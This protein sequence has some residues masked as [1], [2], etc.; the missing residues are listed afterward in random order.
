MGTPTE[1]EYFDDAFLSR[2][3]SGVRE[4]FDSC[5][6]N[7]FGVL[8]EP[9]DYNEVACVCSKLKLG[10]TGLCIDYE[11]ISFAGPPV[12]RLLFEMYQNFYA[13]GSVCESS[14]TG[15]ILP[16]FK[17]KR[18]KANNK[19]NYRGITL[20]PTLCKIYEMV[21]LNRLENYAKQNK[22]F[23][24]LQFGFQEGVGC[25]EAS[26]TILESINHMLERGGKVCGC[27]LDVRKAF[28]TVWID[29]LLYKLFTEFDIRGRMWLAIKDLYTEVRG[30][31]FYSSTLSR[32]FDISQGTGQGRILAS[33]MYKVYINSLLNELTNHCYAISI[34]QLS[35]P[36]PSFADN[37]ALLA[38][39]P[40]FLTSLMGMWYK[41]SIQSGDMNLIML[42]VES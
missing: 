40:T 5:T 12:W 28:D 9:L 3:V 10:V 35:L 41:Y 4:I 24:N 1:N 42:K 7:P 26:F 38:L 32:K 19:D 37:I 13:N 33:F 39:Y 14:K 21:L 31:V 8:C 23:S 29:G 25:T 11:H 22:L 30:Q 6:N 18:A 17:G 15:V 27:F 16:L 36:S 20:F 2:V 34:N